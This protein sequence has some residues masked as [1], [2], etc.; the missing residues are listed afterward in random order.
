MSKTER[1]RL[2]SLT[3]YFTRRKRRD[4]RI[5]FTD[6]TVSVR[7]LKERV[8]GEKCP[9]CGQKALQL[10]KFTKTPTAW[11]AEIQCGNCNLHGVVNSEGSQYLNLHSRGKAVDKKADTK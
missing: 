6:D 9:A 1:S 5:V 3:A 7:D 4:P 8:S 10:V 2:E 11:D